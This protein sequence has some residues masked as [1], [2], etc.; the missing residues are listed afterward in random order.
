MF[1]I[2]TDFGKLTITRS[3]IAEMVMKAVEDTE[4]KA[5][6]SNS[7]GRIYNTTGRLKVFDGTEFVEVTKSGNSVDIRFYVVVKFG[8]SIAA[9]TNQMIDTVQSEMVAITGIEPNSVSVVVTGVMSKNIAKRNIE[10][11]R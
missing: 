1:E 4:G 7:K 9:V 3:V 10:V 6:I 11:R 8:T 2:N 5:F